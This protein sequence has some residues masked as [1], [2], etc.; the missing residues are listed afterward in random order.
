MTPLVSCCL[1]TYNHSDYINQ[2]IESIL[3]QHTDFNFEIIIADDCSKDG[4]KEKIK[5]YAD[6]FPEKIKPII[7]EKN[8]GPAKNFIELLNAATGK[9]IAYLDGDDYW[10]DNLKLQQQ[11]DFLEAN[12]DYAISSHNTTVQDKN[13]KCYLYS[14]IATQ[15]KS[16]HTTFKLID[17]LQ[18]HFIHSSA[19]VFRRSMLKPFPDWYAGAFSGDG[20]LILLLALEGNIHYI[21]KPMSLYRHNSNSIS[22]YSSRIEIN[23]NFEKHFR[24]FDEHS[25]YKFSKEINN[26]IFSLSFYLNYYNTNYLK[27]IIFFSGNFFKII[28]A[29]KKYLP[30]WGRYKFLLPAQIL[31]SRVNINEKKT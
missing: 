30:A 19:L 5:Y 13:K 31:K 1:I 29:N 18:T 10:T 25:N 6:K 12:N 15:K 9:Y 4:T 20:F 17:Y 22:N 11:V 26:K 8:V 7:R 21:N 27:K 28:S 2:A 14:G 16:F 3:M 24:L 23:K